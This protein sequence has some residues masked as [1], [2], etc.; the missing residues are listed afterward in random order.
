LGI[1]K[2]LNEIY[3]KKVTLPYSQTIEVGEQR[4]SR[5]L[6]LQFNIKQDSNYL[7]FR[8]YLGTNLSHYGLS[9]MTSIHMRVRG[10]ARFDVALEEPNESVEGILRKNTWS[11]SAH[12]DWQELILRIIEK[13]LD[14]VWGH[15]P[16]FESMN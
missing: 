10:K 15:I 9:A 3:I 7:L 14:S 5:A 12:L 16:F 6:H 1:T 4:G 11:D 13:Y 2:Q 8:A